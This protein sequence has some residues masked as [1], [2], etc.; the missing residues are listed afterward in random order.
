V[1]LPARALGGVTPQHTAIRLGSQQVQR[2]KGLLMQTM[3]VDE[4]LAHRRRADRQA[5][6]IGDRAAAWPGTPELVARA[7]T[8]DQV[9][10]DQ[11]V[12]RY[13]G[14]VWAVARAHDLSAKNAAVVS[15]VTWLPLTQHLGSLRQ[16][17]ELE[18]W[19]LRTAA[20]EADRMHRL[21]GHE[22]PQEGRLAWPASPEDVRPP[23][24]TAGPACF[25]SK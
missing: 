25:S 8:G 6:G 19:L 20:R 23:R 1:T 3:V 4:R 10:W 21:R 15:Q 2:E 24:S 13:G 5:L 7:G 11:L 14:L 9:A 12:D 17:E 18:D 22:V 16:P